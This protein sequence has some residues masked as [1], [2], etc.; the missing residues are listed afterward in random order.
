MNRPTYDD[1][2]TR[3]LVLE[4]EILRLRDQRLRIGASAGK[5]SA[6]A[7]MTKANP[8]STLS[9]IIGDL[10]KVREHEYLL[11]AITKTM[12]AGILYM[13]CDR[14]P[15][16]YNEFMVPFVNAATRD[17]VFNVRN[18]YPTEEEYQKATDTITRGLRERGAL[19][20]FT[21]QWLRHNNEVRHM[22]I[23]ATSFPANEE[24]IGY[25][26]T[27]IDVT[28]SVK[29]QELLKTVFQTRNDMLLI[30]HDNGDI[31][32]ANEVA[33]D[34]IGATVNGMNLKGL[35]EPGDHGTVERALSSISERKYLD[36]AV[37]L[38]LVSGKGTPVTAELMAWRIDRDLMPDCVLISL[39]D[40]T[41][42]TMLEARN[43][44]LDAQLRA[45][46]E[47]SQD[48]IAIMDR[49]GT[50]RFA[51]PVLIDLLGPGVI[52]GSAF[53]YLHPD[54]RARTRERFA[55]QLRAKAPSKQ[56]VRFCLKDLSANRVYLD[57]LLTDITDKVGYDCV[58]VGCRDV[59]EQVASVQSLRESETR[60]RSIVKAIPDNIFIL[61]RD[62]VFEEYYCSDHIIS[63]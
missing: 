25:I 22:Q 37:T 4:E 8:E 29:G 34:V 24:P 51:N 46:I 60:Y 11:N 2:R 44:E 39:R 20:N 28:E 13:T 31:V 59:T 16:W 7:D 27:S 61:S 26:V 49:R 54:D 21:L 56:P 17:G 5:G 23:S 9:G 55:E 58:V 18:M 53:D 35:V 38:R 33:T 41:A 19:Q 62:G 63:T 32:Y 36:R 15:I 1:L 10:L 48:Y 42:H 30:V 43:R 47:C 57:I 52:G 40:V 45:F 6:A 50:I 12:P 14:K 3:I